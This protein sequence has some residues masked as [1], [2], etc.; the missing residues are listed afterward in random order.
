MSI[1]DFFEWNMLFTLINLIIFFVLIR[2]FLV[3][4]ICRVLDRRQAKIDADRKEAADANAK[5]NELKAQ[6]EEKIQVADQDANE[7]IE[8]AKSDA[9]ADYDKIIVKAQ[10]D[11]KGIKEEAKKQADLDAEKRKREAREE[12]ASLAMETAQKVLGNSVTV[13]SDS[14]IY[15]EFLSEAGE[16]DES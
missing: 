7:I 11:A 16:S 12:I 4:P 14:E 2:L 3:K 1:G 10:Q 15:D 6:Y 13:K 5:A 9:K 8:T